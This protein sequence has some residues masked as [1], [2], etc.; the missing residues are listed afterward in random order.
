MLNLNN[1]FFKLFGDDMKLL[2][3]LLLASLSSAYVFSGH[4]W[5]CTYNEYSSW[6]N[7]SN[8]WR[9]QDRECI[10]YICEMTLEDDRVYWTMFQPW[11]EV[12]TSCSWSNYGNEPTSNMTFI[13][14]DINGKTITDQYTCHTV[15]G[16][17]EVMCKVV[18]IKD[19]Y[20]LNIVVNKEKC[21]LL[22][23]IK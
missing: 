9:C 5:G 21:K 18:G 22:V 1:Y 20:R 16:C 8:V 17:L 6:C 23:G 3:V 2:I 7:A 11:D 4:E 15:D 19:V 12:K 10:D 14:V 13:G